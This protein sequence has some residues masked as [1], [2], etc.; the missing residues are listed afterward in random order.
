M[1]AAMK[2]QWQEKAKAPLGPSRL[3]I[4]AICIHLLVVLHFV[5]NQYF[6]CMC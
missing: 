2:E 3:N 6:C 5:L 4:A 1:I